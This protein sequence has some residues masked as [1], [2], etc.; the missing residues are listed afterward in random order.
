M[1]KGKKVRIIFKLF[2]FGFQKTKKTLNSKNAERNYK[3]L[4]AIKKETLKT[5]A[6]IFR[7]SY[8]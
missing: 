4:S 5:R 2:L 7:A 6:N 3:D 8:F 1:S